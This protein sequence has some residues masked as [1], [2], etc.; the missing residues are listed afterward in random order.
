MR[1]SI[2]EKG[3]LLILRINKFSFNNT[4]LLLIMLAG[5]VARRRFHTTTA[6]VRHQRGGH[7]GTA[8][9]A[10]SVFCVELLL[11]MEA[12]KATLTCGDELWSSLVVEHS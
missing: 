6:V 11:W 1:N 3:L 2:A 4:I 7:H 9:L 5:Y 10:H 12:K 8:Q